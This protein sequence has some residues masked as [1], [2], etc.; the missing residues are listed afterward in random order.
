MMFWS[1][2]PCSTEHGFGYKKNPGGNS[3][4]L[5][6]QS[7]Y[8]EI[9]RYF[10]N[11]YS[12]MFECSILTWT[13]PQC[14]LPEGSS[15]L[16]APH[17]WHQC[18]S[19]TNWKWHCHRFCFHTKQYIK[20]ECSNQLYTAQTRMF[21]S[22][23]MLV[24]SSHSRAKDFTVKTTMILYHFNNQWV[25]TMRSIPFGSGH[26]DVNLW[27]ISNGVSWICPD[28]QYIEIECSCRKQSTG[29]SP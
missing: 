12:I 26:N 17:R 21:F 14:K 5:C 7:K 6:M 8:L 15:G 24:S 9:C 13:D 10:I 11:L 1:E 28:K 22:R 18:F 20:F 2:H 23:N 19:I 29:A 27:C 25:L 4:L 16:Y 3:G